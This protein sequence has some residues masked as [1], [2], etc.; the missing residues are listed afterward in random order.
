M[1]QDRINQSEWDN[2][3]NW[4]TGVY[5]SQ[6]DCRMFVPKRRGIGLTLNFGNRRAVTVF[7]VLLAL[8][9]VAFGVLWLAGFHFGRR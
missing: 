3:Q 6:A 4:S 2:L 8:P 9:L 5:R 7:V 1:T